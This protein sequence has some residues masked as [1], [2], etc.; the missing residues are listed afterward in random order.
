MPVLMELRRV[1]R[2]KWRLAERRVRGVLAHQTIFTTHLPI[3]RPEN[4]RLKAAF[5][6]EMRQLVCLKQDG[7]LYFLLQMTIL[8]LLYLEQNH[9]ALR[10]THLILF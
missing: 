8:H 7:L 10:M 3:A 1:D 6:L 9:L 5:K 4:E 2:R